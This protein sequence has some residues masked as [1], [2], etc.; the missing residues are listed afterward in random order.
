MVFSA[1]PLEKL[2]SDANGE[3]AAETVGSPQQLANLC[4]DLRG[5]LGVILNATFILKHKGAEDRNLLEKYLEVIEREISTADQLLSD[6]VR[7]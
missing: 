1:L 2:L 4:H 7:P 6:L 5:S 3:V